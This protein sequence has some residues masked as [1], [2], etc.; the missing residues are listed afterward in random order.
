[1]TDTIHTRINGLTFAPGY[2][3][4]L[5]AIH[6]LEPTPGSEGVACVLER[7]PHNPYDANAIAVHCPAT[8]GMVG[9]IPKNIARTLAR[10]LDAGERATVSIEIRMHPDHTDQPGADA[11]ITLHPPAPTVS[12][13]DV[14]DALNEQEGAFR[15]GIVGPAPG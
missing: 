13:P 5:Q 11:I 15:S 1:M 8:G 3:A 9:H 4:N 14:L 10:R 12:S 2:P 6:D 7:E